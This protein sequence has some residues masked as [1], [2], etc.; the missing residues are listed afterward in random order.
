MELITYDEG[1]KTSTVKLTDTELVDLNALA[2]GVLATRQ[3]Y[4]I[5]GVQEERLREIK[6]DLSRLLGERFSRGPA[7]RV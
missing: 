1:A 5:L 2:L 3:D 6:R 4:T 7:A